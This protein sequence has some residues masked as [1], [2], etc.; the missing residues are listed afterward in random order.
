M[1]CIGQNKSFLWLI[2]RWLLATQENM[3]MQATLQRVNE[4]ARCKG[5]SGDQA[6]SHLSTKA[7]SSQL[8]L[9]AS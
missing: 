8:V 4:N 2:I 9:R 7:G 5:A 1:R 3:A 6:E